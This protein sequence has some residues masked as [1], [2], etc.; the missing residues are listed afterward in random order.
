[1][2][3]SISICSNSRVRKIK[4]PGVISLRK[5]LPCCAI[6]NG[7]CL[8]EVFNTFLNCT[9]IAC[10]VSGR[11][12]AVDWLTSSSTLV[13]SSIS[14]PLWYA[15]HNKFIGSTGPKKVFN[16]KLNCFG[17]VNSC[18]PPLLHFK[19]SGRLSARMRS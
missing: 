13:N 4:L 14:A 9:N 6:P 3:Y 19:S 15:C 5:A 11:K 10:A 12:Y 18:W 8:R 17:S 2:K 16:I 1:M 7:N